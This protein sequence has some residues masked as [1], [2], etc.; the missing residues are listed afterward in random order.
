MPPTPSS[1]SVDTYWCLPLFLSQIHPGRSSPEG[2]RRRGRGLSALP[3]PSPRPG[4]APLCPHLRSDTE[5]L[6]GGHTAMA[7][8]GLVESQEGACPDKYKRNGHVA[9]APE[10][11][12][13]SAS[14]AERAELP[15]QP[16]PPPAPR[17]WTCHPSPWGPSATLP[18]SARRTPARRGRAT[19]GAAFVLLEKAE[20][21]ERNVLGCNRHR[22]RPPP[23]TTTSSPCGTPGS[24]VRDGSSAG[25]P[26][27][28]V[29]RHHFGGSM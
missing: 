22:H 2:P 21:R 17:T 3:K 6:R 1:S 25:Q 14:G 19:A 10:P 26:P 15:R 5:L 27:S 9:I 18:G 24:A 11:G 23:T 13:P 7:L 8:R 20:I 29:S 16:L 28:R 12:E 4:S